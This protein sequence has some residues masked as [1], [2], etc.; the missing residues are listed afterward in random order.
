M[1]LKNQ[2]LHLIPKSRLLSFICINIC[3]S[4]IWKQL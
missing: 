4:M 1:Y 3:D 2:S